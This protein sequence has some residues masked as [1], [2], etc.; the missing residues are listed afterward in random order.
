MKLYLQW[1][2]QKQ[3][4]DRVNIMF[5]SFSCSH[6]QYFILF[7]FACNAFSPGLE[8]VPSA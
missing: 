1:E 3:H 2:P 6:M 7:E 8:K 5:H 4:T